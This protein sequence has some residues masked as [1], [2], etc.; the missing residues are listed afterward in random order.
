MCVGHLCGKGVDTLGG[1][2]YLWCFGSLF[3]LMALLGLP[4]CLGIMLALELAYTSYITGFGFWWGD[5]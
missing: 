3:N 4:V 1:R 5:G 2:M